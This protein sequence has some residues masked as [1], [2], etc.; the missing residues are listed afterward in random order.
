MGLSSFEKACYLQMGGEQVYAIDYGCP[1]PFAYVLLCCPF[2]SDRL[3]SLGVWAKWAR[4]LASHRIGAVRFDYRG[5]GESTG[6][7]AGMDFCKWMEDVCNLGEWA[8]SRAGKAPMML[9]GMGMG[10]LL[11]QKAFNSGLGDGLL[12]WSPPEK[13]EDILRQGFLV[14]LSMD[15]LL[16][17]PAQRQTP[18]QY[19]AQLK[20]GEIVQVDGYPWSAN[21]WL[22]GE[23]LTLDTEFAAP[24]EGADRCGRPWRH[25]VLQEEMAPL[26][27]SARVLRAMNPRAAIVPD[28]PLN[29]DFSAFFGQNVSWLCRAAEQATRSSGY[30]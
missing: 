16:L 14:R 24:G 1:Q 17:P 8:C 26:T 19:V 18:Q 21:L 23:T 25:L 9:H 5:T 27:R 11:A 30:A 13:A 12:M 22:S 3:F 10:A 28:T 6:D 20:R 29:P 4:F 15:M 2:P 7:F